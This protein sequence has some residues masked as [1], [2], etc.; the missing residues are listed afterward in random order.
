MVDYS[1]LTRVNYS[2][3]LNQK[4]AIAD[5]P[6][7]FM[8][9]YEMGRKLKSR[10]L[11]KG[12]T[13]IEDDGSLSLNVEQARKLNEHNPL[14]ARKYQQMVL[15]GKR[16]KAEVDSLSGPKPTYKQ[17]TGDQAAA[18]GLDASKFYNVAPNNKVSQIGGSG[19]N[20]NVGGSD[21]KVPTGFM[22]NPEKTGEVMPIPGGPQD[23]NT[24][25]K[26]GVNDAQKL[27]GAQN[28]LK[29]GLE[30]Y[31][32]L[33]E[34]HGIALMPG[35]VKDQMLAARRNIQLQMKELYNLGVLAGPDMQLMD[36][37][38]VDPTSFGS[39][40]LHILPGEGGDIE[41]RAKNN[42]NQLQGMFENILKSNVPKGMKLDSAQQGVPEPEK[43]PVDQ[44][45]QDKAIED[46]FKKYGV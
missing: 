6:D 38:L 5:A 25:T 40:F 22:R 9:Y 1:P 16:Q 33:I 4:S 8:N 43:P 42:I 35:T 31:R 3:L 11:A 45:Q 14:Q 15:D 12:V 32:A 20:V 29:Q 41:I 27:M 2:G 21:F 39:A 24:P 10:N 17:V 13:N 37:L 30:N 7:N 23:P 36:E 44:D 28:A 18:M 34:E 46:I 19:V 26:A